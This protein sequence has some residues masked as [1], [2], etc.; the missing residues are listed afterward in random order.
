[1]V[2]LSLTM[3]LLQMVAHHKKEPL[4]A[5]RRRC[6]RCQWVVDTLML[7]DVGVDDGSSC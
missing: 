5:T 4:L 1:M 3:M 6:S 2:T 7:G